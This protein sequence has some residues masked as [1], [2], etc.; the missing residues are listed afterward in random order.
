MDLIQAVKDGWVQNVKCLCDE[1]MVNLDAQD[2]Y[3]KTALFYA[4]E[5]GNNGIVKELCDRGANLEVKD[6]CGHTAL[7]YGV[8][9]KYRRCIK[10]LCS[11]GAK[12]H[13]AHSNSPAI[14]EILTKQ[15]FRHNLV[16]LIGHL[17]TQIVR[18][19]HKWIT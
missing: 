11:K 19:I 13:D 10:I 4:V 9:L 8:H 2:E 7:S 6:R 5:F 15:Q 12:V 18:E 14:K 1:S 16:V 3:G 17:P